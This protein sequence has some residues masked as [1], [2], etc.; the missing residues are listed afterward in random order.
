MRPVRAQNLH[1]REEVAD[2]PLSYPGLWC[3][4]SLDLLILYPMEFDADQLLGP[5]YHC[6]PDALIGDQ[7]CKLRRDR[8]DYLKRRSS[9]GLVA[10]ETGDCAPTELDASGLHEATRG[11]AVRRP[12]CCATCSNGRP[13]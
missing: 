10:N 3:G 8:A 7:K 6:A 5:P 12:N 11:C 1:Y 9:L 4:T 13:V 2:E